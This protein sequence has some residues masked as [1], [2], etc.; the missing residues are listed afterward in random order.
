MGEGHRKGKDWEFGISRYK[1]LCIG[2]IS[3]KVL[4]IAQELY[5]I[6][7]DKSCFLSLWQLRWVENMIKRTAVGNRKIEEFLLGHSGLRIQLQRLWSLRR[8]MFHP[9]PV[10]WVKGSSIAPTWKLPYTMGMGI[11]K[12]RKKEED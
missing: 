2:W 7:Y 11:W 6:S 12:K 10:W 4:L 3:N 9:D 5:S 1:L 8:C